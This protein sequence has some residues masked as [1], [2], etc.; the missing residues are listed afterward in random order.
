ML[1]LQTAD[2]CGIYLCIVVL[3]YSAE[4]ASPGRHHDCLCPVVSKVA[5]AKLFIA[6]GLAKSNMISFSAL[7]LLLRPNDFASIQC[8]DMI[9]QIMLQWQLSVGACC[10]QGH[11]PV[12]QKVAYYRVH[13][14]VVATRQG[15]FAANSMS[16]AFVAC[17]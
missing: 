3:V 6:V 7:L 10:M 2:C 9:I 1:A 11:P 5:F 15:C 14:C 16:V 13:T 8:Y 17:L 12:V 4:H